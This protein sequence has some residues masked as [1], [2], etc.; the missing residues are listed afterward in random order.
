M[1]HDDFPL[2]L[3]QSIECTSQIL[4]CRIVS[5]GWVEP[6]RVSLN[7]YVSPLQVGVVQNGVTYTREKI[8][9]LVCRPAE[10][11]VFDELQKHLVK[12][13]LSTAAVA[14]HGVREQQQ[15]RPV[16]AVPDLNLVRVLFSPAHLLVFNVKTIGEDQFV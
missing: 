16:L 11:P 6:H 5:V 10:T 14:R 1:Q 9:L 2:I 15:G 12:R 7:G 8:G 3:G 13:V 4:L